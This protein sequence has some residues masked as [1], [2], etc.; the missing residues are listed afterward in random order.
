MSQQS[1]A[2]LGIIDI[3]QTDPQ[4]LKY[5]QSALQDLK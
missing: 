1:S 4:G 2:E 5:G 3:T